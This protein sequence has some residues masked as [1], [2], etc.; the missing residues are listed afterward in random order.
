MK[1]GRELKKNNT[2][3]SLARGLASTT[4]VVTILMK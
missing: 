3:T 1:N 2:R 4:D